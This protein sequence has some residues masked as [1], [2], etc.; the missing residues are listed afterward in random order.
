MRAVHRPPPPSFIDACRR[1]NANEVHT[2]LRSWGSHP[3]PTA[4]LLEAV[5]GGTVKVGDTR[6][7]SAAPTVEEARSG[8]WGGALVATA[9]NARLTLRRTRHERG[10]DRR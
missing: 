2:L 8:A 7:D 10:R 1:G 6:V 3:I 4:A 5:V 9:A